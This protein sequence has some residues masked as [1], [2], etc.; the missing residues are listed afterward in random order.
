MQRNWSQVV[1]FCKIFKDVFSVIL[2]SWLHYYDCWRFLPRV[3]EL[4]ILT[5][6]LT[7]ERN[8]NRKKLQCHYIN[9]LTRKHNF[10][11]ID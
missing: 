2:S 3:A 7:L 4:R 8:F 11:I 10:D 9:P 6:S 1:S 5:S